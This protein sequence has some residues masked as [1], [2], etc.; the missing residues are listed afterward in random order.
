MATGTYEKRLNLISHQRKINENSEI[1]SPLRMVVIV[2]ATDDGDIVVIMEPWQACK[3]VQSQWKS[4]RRCLRKLR[5]HL[6][7]DTAIPLL[8]IYVK[9]CRS[10]H[11][12]ETCTLI[13]IAALFTITVMESAKFSSSRGMEKENMVHRQGVFFFQ[14]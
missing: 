11:L 12:R 3:L 10:T 13:F 8:G 9:Y 1:P 7:Q 5:I 2:K 14:L 4:V 6:S